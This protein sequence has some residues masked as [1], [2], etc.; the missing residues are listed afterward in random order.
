[1]VFIGLMSR[2]ILKSIFRN[3]TTA[4][5][6]NSFIGTRLDIDITNASGKAPRSAF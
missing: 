5:L 1:M 6:R 3:A 2:I 4:K